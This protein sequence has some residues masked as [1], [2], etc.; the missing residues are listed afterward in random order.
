MRID[1]RE[2]IHA[3]RG[4]SRC[5]SIEGVFAEKGARFRGKW[6]LGAPPPT[7]G[8]SP[9]PTPGGPGERGG[10]EGQGCV[11]GIWGGAGAEAPFTAKTSPLFGENA[12]SPGHLRFATRLINQTLT[13]PVSPYPLNLGG[14]ISPLNSGGGVSETPCFTVF[15][16]VHPLNLGGEIAT[17]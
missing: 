6:G 16:G 8:P 7:P 17:P 2:S 1:S 9:P 10:G 3:N 15:S 11:R 13:F 14:A 5:V 4:D 12:L